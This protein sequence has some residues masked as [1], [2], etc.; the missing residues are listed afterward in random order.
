MM[1][2]NAEITPVFH[3]ES[4]AEIPESG[5][6]TR[7]LESVRNL[8]SGFFYLKT[9]CCTSIPRF[10]KGVS[11][12]WAGIWISTIKS[13]CCARFQIP[14]FLTLRGRCPPRSR[15]ERHHLPRGR[16]VSPDISSRAVQTT[17]DYR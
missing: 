12:I 14:D 6:I 1:D 16:L 15:R 8:E 3:L 9:K 7:N 4:G 11:E 10:R 5:Q 2:F 17:G 13:V